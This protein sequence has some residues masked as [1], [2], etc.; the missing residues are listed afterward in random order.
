V[1]NE[2]N[3]IPNSVEN[4]KTKTVQKDKINKPKKSENEN[5]KE[6]QVQPKKVINTIENKKD[7]S[8][9]NSRPKILEDVVIIRAK[10]NFKNPQ[11]LIKKMDEK[12]KIF[13]KEKQQRLR[14]II[15]EG[16]GIMDRTVK[17]NSNLI[18]Q[19]A[20]LHAD[21]LKLQKFNP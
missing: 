15:R 21:H 9:D 7:E 1:P 17:V 16:M 19:I 2:V 6:R 5:K 11:D 12:L 18:I 8:A 14:Q 10:P 20:E 3:V 4:R 13:K